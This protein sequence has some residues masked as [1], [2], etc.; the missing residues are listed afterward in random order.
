MNEG[1]VSNGNGCRNVRLRA[2]CSLLAPLIGRMVQF[3]LESMDRGDLDTGDDW[4][5]R[6]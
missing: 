5:A 1:V 2:Y 3:L 6:S 4:L